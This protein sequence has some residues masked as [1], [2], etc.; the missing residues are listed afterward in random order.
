[1]CVVLEGAPCAHPAERQGT[2]P[3]LAGVEGRSATFGDNPT[4]LLEAV[5]G[6]VELR[7]N[8]VGAAHAVGAGV[9]DSRG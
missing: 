3:V 2:A 7:S 9:S 8:L 5:N 6:S 4:Y 1:M